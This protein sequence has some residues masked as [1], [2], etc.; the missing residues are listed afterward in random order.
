MK[1]LAVLVACLA[2]VLADQVKLEEGSIYN[3]LTE[4]DWKAYF[5]GNASESA[6]TV[7][8]GRTRSGKDLFDYIGLGTGPETDP[9]LARANELCLSGDLSECFKS[10]AL[11]SLDDFFTKE[12][13][14]SISF[15]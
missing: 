9:Y 13:R 15:G 3:N 14:H 6:N 10:R 8:E 11:A 7:P 1:S 2:L 4:T 12:G 5:F